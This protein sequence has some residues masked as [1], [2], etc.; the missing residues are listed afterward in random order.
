MSERFFFDTNILLYAIDP[1]DPLKKSRAIELIATHLDTNSM[2][3]STQV[4]QEFYAIATRKLKISA[5]RSYALAQLYSTTT[6]IQVASED[7]FYAMRM[8]QL[9]PL[10]FWDALIVRSAKLARVTK[11]FSEDMNSNQRYDG[12]LIDNPLK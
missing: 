8:H 5:E 9:E 2:V 7:I 12:M 11:I 10:S 3:V 4:L 1:R 6:V